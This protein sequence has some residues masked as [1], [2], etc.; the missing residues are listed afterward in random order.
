MSALL[1]KC[2]Q[3]VWLLFLLLLFAAGG[4]SRAQ[5]LVAQTSVSSD[6]AMSQGLLAWRPA[7]PGGMGPAIN[8]PQFKVFD[9]QGRLVFHGNAAAARQWAASKEASAPIAAQLKVR[10]L[11]AEWRLL[12]LPLPTPSVPVVLLYIAE[13]CPPCADLW[14]GL[15]GPLLER[16]GPRAQVHVI[17]VGESLAVPR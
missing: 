12:K 8:V 2:R 14:A 15:K 4:P 13:P 10:E 9:G 7:V 3:R 16:M 17:R 6:L 5:S 11:A 1:S